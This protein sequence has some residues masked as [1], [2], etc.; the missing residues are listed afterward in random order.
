M[1]DTQDPTPKSFSPLQRARLALEGLSVG[2][3]F[4]ERFFR[5]I[6]VA[7]RMIAERT[8]PPETTWFYTDDTEMALS[9]Y[10]LLKTYGELDQDLLA[11]EFCERHDQGRGYG[12]GMHRYVS[13][14]RLGADW[15]AVARDLFGGTGSYGNGGAM[16][17][18]P[19]GAF[20]ADDLDLVA[21]QAAR[22][23][24][25]TH[26]H[27][28]GIAGAVAV[29]VAA[30]LAWRLRE[31]VP[32][33]G[34]FLDLILERTPAGEVK[35]G[36]LNARDMVDSDSVDYAVSRLGNGTAISAADTV[37]FALWC[38]AKTLDSFEDAMW[39]TV[40]GFGDRDTTCA[41]VGGIVALSATPESLPDEW[42]ARRER[43]P[44]WCEA[45]IK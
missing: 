5:D 16:R 38:A 27:P 41:I 39:L 24:E 32:G 21:E 6:P 9:V 36:I 13:Q 17:V 18:A 8:L 33:P 28:D 35:Q 40:S 30:A 4:G 11:F 45:E 20:F 26:A 15:R 7:E 37:P 14:V 2:D 44:R 12:S 43:L 34:E 19:L 1:T 23:A 31:T 22:S 10:Y 25:V 42:V 3:A 29:A